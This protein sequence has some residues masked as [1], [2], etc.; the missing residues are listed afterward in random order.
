[1]DIIFLR[2]THVDWLKCLLAIKRV[3]ITVQGLIFLQWLP[4]VT[5]STKLVLT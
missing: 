1:M 3:K 5:N 2:C 4:I